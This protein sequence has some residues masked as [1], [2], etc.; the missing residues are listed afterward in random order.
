MMVHQVEG[1]HPTTPPRQT[2]VTKRTAH[3]QSLQSTAYSYDLARRQCGQIGHQDFRLL[4]AQVPPSF[5]QHQHDFTDMTQTQAR[6]VGPK[7]SAAVPRLFSGHPGA[8]KIR[9]RHMRHEV[10]D[11]F[12]FHRL[13]GTS[14]CK[15]KAPTS[16]RISLITI[17]DHTHI[18]LGAIG[19]IPPTITSFAQLG[20]TNS[21]PISRHRA[22]SL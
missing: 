18:R 11:G 4:G 12:L 16:S 10:F 13:P 9:V 17:L 1:E 8:L 15:D 19:G 3:N 6:M 20:G 22:C 7:G 21:P 2:Y 14:D 5:A